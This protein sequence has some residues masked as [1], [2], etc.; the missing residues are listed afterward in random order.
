MEQVLDFPDPVFRPAFHRDQIVRIDGARLR[1]AQRVAF[2][3]LI[4]SAPHIHDREAALY[5]FFGSFV[6]HQI[7]LALSGGAVGVIVVHHLHGFAQLLF[8]AT[9]SS[10]ARNV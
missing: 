9:F 8:A 2:D 7:A 4:D 10:P 1:E 6:A 5:Q 3:G